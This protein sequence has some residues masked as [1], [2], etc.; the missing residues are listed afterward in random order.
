MVRRRSS[1]LRPDATC[2]A[3]VDEARDL[4]SSI[5]TLPDSSYMILT[6]CAPNVPWPKFGRPECDLAG[7]AAMQA[8]PNESQPIS[9]VARLILMRYVAV[10][11]R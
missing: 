10:P 2:A 11:L 6:S 7:H 9:I 3:S 4:R 1:D 8:L 5:S